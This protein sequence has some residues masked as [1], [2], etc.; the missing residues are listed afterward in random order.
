MENAQKATVN[1]YE[2]RYTKN[3]GNLSSVELDFEIKKLERKFGIKLKIDDAPEI[4]KTVHF[5][6]DPITYEMKQKTP[7]L[8][9]WPFNDL[10]FSRVLS[11]NKQNV[12]VSAKCKYD[13][14]QIQLT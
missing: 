1:M 13:R 5:D 11:F 3:E 14:F 2:L 9:L 7:I 6:E 4:H 12:I 8:R 10:E